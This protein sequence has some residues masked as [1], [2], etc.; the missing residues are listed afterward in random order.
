M[1]KNTFSPTQPTTNINNNVIIHDLMKVTPMDPNT[2]RSR[3]IVSHQAKKTESTG[4]WDQ[5]TGLLSADTR[6]HAYSTDVSLKVRYSWKMSNLI[7]IIP[8]FKLAF[9][10]KNSTRLSP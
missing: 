3:L 9:Q 10:T 8:Y 4:T 1:I 6:K 2:L 5:G 7:L